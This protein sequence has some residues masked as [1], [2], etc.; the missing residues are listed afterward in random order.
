MY[1]TG[2]KS[3]GAIKDDEIRQSTHYSATVMTGENGENEQDSFVHMSVPRSGIG[4]VGYEK[5]DGAEFAF[6][7]GMTQSWTSFTYSTDIWVKI[8]LL[9]GSKIHSADDVTISPN[10]FSHFEKKMLDDSTIAI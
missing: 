6:N 4:K 9:D 10:K 5:E 1:D 2:I 7:N 3:E 8:S